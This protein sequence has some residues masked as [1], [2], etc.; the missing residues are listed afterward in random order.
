MLNSCGLVYLVPP[1]S[2]R[3][4]RNMSAGARALSCSVRKGARELCALNPE[5]MHRSAEA[6]MRNHHETY[7]KHVDT[8]P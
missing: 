5:D 3:S 1:Y 7:M 8:M 6:G 4:S 2:G